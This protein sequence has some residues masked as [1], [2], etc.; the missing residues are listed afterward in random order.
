M[1]KIWIVKDANGIVCGIA[2]TEVQA[3]RQA[4]WFLP[5][6]DYKIS[7]EFIR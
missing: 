5:K 1:T 6:A 2:P 3:R 7:M 4:M